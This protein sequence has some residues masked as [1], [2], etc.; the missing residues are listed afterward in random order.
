MF[1]VH[2]VYH[3]HMLLFKKKK[4]PKWC[5]GQKKT[6]YSVTVYTWGPPL[7]QTKVAYSVFQGW[8]MVCVNSCILDVKSQS[9]CS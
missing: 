1:Y 3:S 8:G 7:N 2:Q 6:P 5:E 4:I 9:S